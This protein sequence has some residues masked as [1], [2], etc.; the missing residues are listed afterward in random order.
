MPTRDH[1]KRVVHVA[2]ASSGDSQWPVVGLQ[3]T[4]AFLSAGN[5][6]VLQNIARPCEYA[7]DFS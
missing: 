2:L 5:L 7:D 3:N 1:V 4:R 6:Q